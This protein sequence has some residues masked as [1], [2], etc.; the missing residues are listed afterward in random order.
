M[1]GRPRKTVLITKLS[2]LKQTM[3]NLKSRCKAIW[4]ILKQVWYIPFIWSLAWFSY[5]IFRATL[6]LKTPILQGDAVNYLGTAISIV[7]LLVA[8]YGAKARIKK[9]LQTTTKIFTSLKKELPFHGD[10]LKKNNRN[11]SLLRKPV[12]STQLDRSMQPKPQ[13]K[14]QS[15]I[16]TNHI[17]KEIKIAQEPVQPHSSATTSYGSSNQLSGG[18]SSQDLSSECLTC[19]HLIKCTHRQKRAI[20]L[21]SP[22]KVQ[23][24]C[25]FA[26]DFSNKQPQK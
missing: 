19:A 4:F 24:V 14:Q 20:E 13:L 9:P 15:P 21:Q 10:Y 1:I 3:S 5:W 25:R 2:A 8:G 7:A 18:L 22:G 23:T 16:E 26:T 11:Q 12:Q 6:V 17:Q